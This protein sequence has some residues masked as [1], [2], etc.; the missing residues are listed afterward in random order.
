MLITNEKFVN[1]LNQFH[2]NEETFYILLLLFVPAGNKLHVFKNS[3]MYA[4]QKLKLPFSV[5]LN[6]GIISHLFFTNSISL[7]RII[8]QV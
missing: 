8:P 2:Q 1:L 4:F 6:L 5:N 3:I 7:P